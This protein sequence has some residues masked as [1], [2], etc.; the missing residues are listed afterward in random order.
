MRKKTVT[1][2]LLFNAPCKQVTFSE[3]IPGVKVPVEKH[4]SEEQAQKV[5]GSTLVA[6]F[7]QG[8]SN[9]LGAHW[10]LPNVLLG[11]KGGVNV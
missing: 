3:V 7:C 11:L 6:V 1:T 8:Y 2:S 10:S 5:A 9:A 4:L